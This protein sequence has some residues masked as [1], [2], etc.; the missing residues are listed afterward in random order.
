MM[1]KLFLLILYYLLVITLYPNF[2]INGS[3]IFIDPFSL[4]FKIAS[5]ILLIFELLLPVIFRFIFKKNLWKS[6]IY[7]FIFLLFIIILEFF[8]YCIIGYHYRKFSTERW[9]DRKLCYIRFVML[10]DLRKNY[11]LEGQSKEDIYNLL[12][13]IENDRCHYQEVISNSHNFNQLC[14]NIDE[15]YTSLC[16]EFDYD[17]Y[18]TKVYEKDN[19]HN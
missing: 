5:I 1:K 10:D 15:K 17:G 18:V 4:V 6:I 8:I 16:L 19:Y 14:Y 3:I 12:G 13:K 9:N 7:C 11:A 2:D